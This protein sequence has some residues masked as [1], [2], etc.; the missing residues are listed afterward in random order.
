MKTDK[1]FQNVLIEVEKVS[2]S[3]TRRANPHSIITQLINPD[4]VWLKLK[5]EDN[6][7]INIDHLNLNTSDKYSTPDP[8]RRAI[9]SHS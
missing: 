3:L 4:C 2:A 1:E 9:N 8:I 5:L 6:T 7:P